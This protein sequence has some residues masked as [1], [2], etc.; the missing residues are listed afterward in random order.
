M[1]ITE[2]YVSTAGAGAHDG[3]SAANALTFSEMVT[4]IN[5]LGAGGGAGRR[6]NIT[7]NHT[8]RG[9]SDTITVGGTAT[10]PMILRGYNATIG[11]LDNGTRDS[12]GA[13][14]VTNTPQITY[15][16]GNF[17]LAITT[18]SNVVMQNLDVSND[19]NGIGTNFAVAGYVYNCRFGNANTGSNAVVLNSA[20]GVSLINCDIAPNAS[21][22]GVG[23]DV[24]TS[25][26]FIGCRIVGYA[27]SGIEIGSAN[28]AATAINCTISGCTNGFITTHASTR[29]LAVGCTIQGCTNGA[30]ILS[31][32]TA[33]HQF[34]VCMITD[35]SGFGIDL[36]GAGS[37]AIAIISGCRFRD[38]GADTDGTAADWTEATDI[39]N[40]TTD[41]GGA[42]TDYTD[43]TTNKDFS[44][45]YG[46]P[47][48]QQGFS[49]LT[50]IGACGIPIPTP[51]EIAADFWAN[52]GSLTG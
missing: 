4:Q 27:G 30:D 34:H 26:T 13:L 16:A 37:G 31:T 22:T 9:A 23:V 36:N 2:Y 6:Y 51:A 41:T 40:I 12:Y 21:A 11:D 17:R 3:T 20:G 45:V 48:Y 29:I 18:G 1:A 28:Q 32:S 8:A 14:V 49:Q 5:A 42:T 15:S 52:S 43:P 50:N 7:G 25:T 24:S 35:N 10:S 19:Y 38:N 39:R 46:S 47:G 33:V 44:L